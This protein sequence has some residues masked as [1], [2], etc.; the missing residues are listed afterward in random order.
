MPT[1]FDLILRHALYFEGARRGIVEEF[2][3]LTSDLDERMMKVL[4]RVNVSNLGEL[5]K[6]D[7][8]RIMVR[9][10]SE[11]NAGFKSDLTAFN[12]KMRQLS[13]IETSINQRIFRA[14]SGRRVAVDSADVWGQAR[15]KDIAATG[16]NMERTARRF[17]DSAINDIERVL[18][19]GYADKSDLDAILRD[20]RGTGQ[21]F[22]GSMNRI[23]AWADSYS[24]TVSKHVSSNS[25]YETSSEYYDE[26]DWVSIIDDVTTQICRD[27]NGNRYRYGEG[28]I[29]PAHYRCRSEIVPVTGEAVNKQSLAE[30]LEDQPGEFLSD[31][32]KNG[33]TDLDNVKVI[34]LDELKG[35]LEFILI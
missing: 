30:W 22:G 35:K 18:R 14:D 20:L 11:L 19:R 8:N 29:P 24:D 12:R 13:D 1:L 10:R 3:P 23:Q 9:L 2:R 16:S 21:D 5:T 15:A 17:R 26:Y 34:T 33:R 28:P 6:A 7:F 32:F 27:R 4:R 25:K 31:V